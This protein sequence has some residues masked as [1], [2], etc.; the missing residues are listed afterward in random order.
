MRLIAWDPDVQTVVSRI[1]AGAL[2]LQPN[3]QRGEVWPRPKKQ[4][5]IDSILR[6][7]HV[8][9]LH[10]VENEATRM[11]EVLDGQQRLVAIRDFVR[12][13]LR[14]DGLTEPIDPAIEALHGLHYHDLPVDVR[15]R[16]DQFP[17]R[18]YRIV[19]YKSAEPAEL[20]FRLNQ[21]TNLTGA[22]QRNAFFGP[23]RQQ[24]KSLVEYLPGA[25][26]DKDLLGFSNT[27]MAYDDVLCRVALTLERGTISLKVGSGDLVAMYRSE[28]PISGRSI[29][30]LRNAIALI[31]A[32]GKRGE[33][34]PR[35]NKATIYS[36]F[37]FVLRGL[38]GLRGDLMTVANL[39]AFMSY[40]EGERNLVVSLG[41]EKLICGLHANWLL[42]AYE[43]RATSRV[44]DASSVMLR[45]I[46]L[47]LSFSQ[48]M[49]DGQHDDVEDLPPRTLKRV[50]EHI[51]TLDVEDLARVGSDMGWGRLS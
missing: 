10:V 32:A 24:I 19:D 20:F 30:L 21:P 5:L 49:L 31:G 27:R 41:S 13:N 11:Q 9:P 39:A 36:W 46:A 35:F 29:D 47:W 15:R 8:P 45:D 51:S 12:G 6:E 4:R 17:L 3:F 18:I 28:D 22:E 50:L 48:F 23:V 42:S 33:H 40:F 14:I 1:D 38:T 7:W 44:A 26:V 34:K 2:D 37:I 25:G 16:F 43:D